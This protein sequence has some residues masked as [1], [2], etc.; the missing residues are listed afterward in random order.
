MPFRMHTRSSVLRHAGNDGTAAVMEQ[1]TAADTV[2]HRRVFF[3]TIVELGTGTSVL[4]THLAHPKWFVVRNAACLLGA[5]RTVDAE[6][7]LI[8]GLAHADERVRTSVAT[9]LIQLGTPAGRRALKN[10]IHD[11]S[12]QVRRRILESLLREDGV[13]TRQQ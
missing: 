1:L 2:F 6:A 5:M 12:S 8:K 7:A 3:D 10:A 11:S 13:A 4:I 9:A